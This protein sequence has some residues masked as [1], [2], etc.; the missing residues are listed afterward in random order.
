M[1]INNGIANFDLD[2][3]PA[4]PQIVLAGAEGNDR[5]S[6]ALQ[7]I[8]Y[9]QLAPRG[10]FAYRLPGDKTVLRAGARGSSTPT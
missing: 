3:D 8:N 1:D 7:G 4:H 6:R 5:A 2:T 9:N 10:G